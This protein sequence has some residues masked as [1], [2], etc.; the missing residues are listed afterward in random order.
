MKNDLLHAIYYWLRNFYWTIIRRDLQKGKSLLLASDEI[1]QE[2]KNLL[3][4][5]SLD[6][7]R[8]DTMYAPGRAVAYLSVGLSAIRCINKALENLSHNLTVKSILDFPGGSGRVLRFLRV[9]FPEADITASE[10]DLNALEFCKNSFNVNIFPSKIPLSDVVNP[11]RYDLIW[12]GSLFTHIDEKEAIELL[13]FFY[14][15][16]TDEGVCV[17]STHGTLS[18]EWLEDVNKNP[19]GIPD[20]YQKKVLSEYYAKGYGYTDYVNEPGYGISAV[21]RQ[22]LNEMAKSVGDWNEI[23]FLEHGWDNHQDVYAF[24]R[25]KAK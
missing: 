22:R 19:Y 5:V 13:K 16:L 10:L 14:D 11:N 17:F 9:K 15:H 1:T 7:N 18:I 23:V 8:K 4:K 24:S 25:Q 3:D 12:C 2:E 21:T 6:I 20:D